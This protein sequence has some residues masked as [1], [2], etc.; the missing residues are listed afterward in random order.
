MR[1]PSGWIGG[2]AVAAGLLATGAT[3]ADEAVTVAGPTGPLA[4]SYLAP[5]EGG[6]VMV[7]IPGSG[8]TDRN[9]NSPLG[10]A[11]GAYQRLAEALA[12]Q[13][14]GSIR[15]DKRGMFGS[16]GA[17]ADPNAVR[18]SDYAGDVRAWAAEARRRSGAP[19]AWLLGH[20]EG[21]LV[22]ILAAQ[23]SPD[24][25]GLVLLA[26]PGRPLQQVLREQLAANPA[27]APVMG[28]VDA[29]IAELEAGRPP[30]LSG[31][32]PAVAMLFNPALNTYFISLF[33]HDP[34]AELARYA[35]PVLVVQGETDI[36]VTLADAERLAQA[37]GLEPVIIPGMNHV[38]RDAPA[39]RAANAATY[40]LTDAPLSAG[41]AD[42]I[43][44]FVTGR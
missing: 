6:P 20:S 31:M 22:A 10:V 40:R 23:D 38:L 21:G 25:C 16:A 17:A 15:I 35:G 8:P 11:G 34:A 26:A 2:L 14:V 24:V 37:R 39:D 30:D 18:L 28:Q 42:A 32:H 3:A 7:I 41:L 36:Q 44:G 33:S 13:G 29:I 9:G 1:L 43:A 19:C 5:V 27:N 12:A 4:G